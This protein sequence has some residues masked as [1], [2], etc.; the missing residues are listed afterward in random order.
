MLAVNVFLFAFISQGRMASFRLDALLSAYPWWAIV[1]A[2]V[3][4]FIARYL[5]K[6]SE[7]SYKHNSIT[8][9]GVIVSSIL[10]GAFLLHLL[11]FDQYMA[12]KGHFRGMYHRY[13]PRMDGTGPHGG[14]MM[15]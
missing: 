11:G 4:F 13:A 6:K 3:A 5:Y 9:I 1:V 2:L 15:R 14:N 7:S 12:R 10:L 8:I